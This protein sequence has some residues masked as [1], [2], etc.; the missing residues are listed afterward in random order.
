MPPDTEVFTLSY[1][2]ERHRTSEIALERGKATARQEVNIID[3]GLVA[4][5]GHQVGASGSDKIEIFV[6]ETRATPGYH[7]CPLTPGQWQIIVGAYKV[8]PAGVAVVYE[9]SFTPKHLRL[10]K[11]DLHTHTVASDGVLT[12]EELAQHALWQ[13]LDF[14]A[15]TDHNQVAVPDTLPQLPGLT[16]I[17][18]VEW[19]HYQGHARFLGV[20]KPYDGPFFTNTVEEMQARF[21]SARERGALITIDHPFEPGCEFKFDLQSIPFDCIEVWNGPVRESNLKAMGLWYSLLAA[22]KKIPICGGSDYHRDTLFVFL[23][24]PTTC[25]YA[26]SPS[27]ADILT[28]LKQG[29]GY[30]TFAPDGPA[31]EM[32]AGEAMLGDS[33][34][35]AQVNQLQI[36]ARGLLAGDVV[37]V[38][39]AGGRTPVY[40]AEVDGKWEGNYPMD[41]PGFA[42]VEVL[43]S[44]VP[45][46]P[47]L[48]ALVS[49]PIYFDP[50]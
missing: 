50:D 6:G 31:L 48:P 20:E 33:V 12:V 28:A 49:N 35:F 40:T 46:L 45:G 15:I 36:A 39:T 11:G 25:L 41:A 7:P 38:V 1:H 5:D 24:G 27:P 34:P 30:I 8:A 43:R 37:N 4:P 47:L 21:A 16:L 13:G 29:H 10:L 32:S 42:Y 14:L 22:G 17:P 3:L 44:F 19:T 2:Y 9:L 26:M 18:G 23:G